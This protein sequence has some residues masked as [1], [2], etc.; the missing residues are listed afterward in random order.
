MKFIKLTALSSL[1]LPVVLVGCSSGGDDVTT[2]PTSEVT[3]P[4]PEATNRAPEAIAG[5]DT[6]VLENRSVTLDASGSK[7]DDGDKLNYQWMQVSGPTVSLSNTQ[8]AEPTFIAPGV[9][10]ATE[11]VF[12]L[13]A[14]DAHDIK[15]IDSVKVTVLQDL[16]KVEKQL[17]VIPEN[18][19]V[20]ADGN[21]LVIAYTYNA[22]N[23]NAQTAGL[24]LKLHWD[25]SK[26]LFKDINEVLMA[27]HLG[28]SSVMAD[29]KDSDHNSRT[30]QY[31]I[32]SWIDFDGVSWPGD[33]GSQAKLFSAQFEPIDGATGSSQ[34]TVS[35]HFTSPGYSLR[36]QTVSV[37]L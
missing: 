23:I 30:D 37:E 8:S 31:V 28:V 21:A 12:E 18:T 10:A 27:N 19:V 17:S 1:I 11:L 22:S 9:D 25:S 33:L 24:S 5:V 20:E 13:E 15:A 34:V 4:E 6:T 29:T 35:R 36:S 3:S 7:D 16:E 26:L 2:V 14:V 32:L